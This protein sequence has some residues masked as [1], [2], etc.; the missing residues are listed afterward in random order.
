MNGTLKSDER[1][2]DSS[3]K[4]KM[5]L[6][7]W[8]NQMPTNLGVAAICHVVLIADRQQMASIDLVVFFWRRHRRRYDAAWRITASDTHQS[9]S[10]NIVITSSA[11]NHC[12]ARL[13]LIHIRSIGICLVG[14]WSLLTCE[15]LGGWF[16]L[17]ISGEAFSTDRVSLHM[18]RY[19]LASPILR[20]IARFYLAS[21]LQIY[22]KSTI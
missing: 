1:S 3:G 19:C 7:H 18:V 8:I 9:D 15:V 16:D 20:D 2:Y 10:R 13:S 5:R 6:S 22:S 21:S 14:Q 4:W 12:R 11:I 17:A